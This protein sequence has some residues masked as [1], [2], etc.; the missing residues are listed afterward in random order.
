MLAG[1]SFDP[2]I[3]TGTLLE[4]AILVGGGLLTLS[5]LSTKFALFHADLSGVK[6]DVTDM[7]SEIK[8]VNELLA[9]ARDADRRI[10]R[11]EDDMREL[12]HKDGY[13]IGKN[14]A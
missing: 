6:T 7:K 1:I 9:S 2:T 13:V 5:K 3:T 10:G 12:R 11:L 4:C 8:K 14:N